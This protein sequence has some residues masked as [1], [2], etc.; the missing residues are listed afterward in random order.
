MGLDALRQETLAVWPL[1]E[2]R[3]EAFEPGPNAAV[4]DA[5]KGEHSLFIH[6]PH[7]SGKTH[8]AQALIGQVGGFYLQLNDSALVP[9]VLEGLE[10]FQLVILDG[11]ESV[12]GNPEWE[13]SLFAFW[14]ACLDSQT[15]ILCFALKPVGDLPI[16]LPDLR[17]RVGQLPHFAL[18]PLSEADIAQ[19]LSR[20]AR[21]ADLRLPP[22]VI[23][24]L[25]RHH[26]RSIG[27]LAAM[28]SQIEQGALRLQRPV[29]IPLVKQ[30]LGARN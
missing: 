18:R 29:T 4:V 9:E 13:S 8:L 6:G 25:L 27:Q 5:L 12:M 14:N 10:S 17:S 7:G 3:L 16:S 2:T 19:A 11:F 22:E 15:R 26:A 21:V 30:I 28:L 23:E 20:R 1:P 24:Y